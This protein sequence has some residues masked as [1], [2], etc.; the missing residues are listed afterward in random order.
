M[1]KIQ[2]SSGE[3]DLDPAAIRI[4]GPDALEFL[5]AQLTLDLR[6][7]IPDRLQATAWCNANG[8]VAVVLLIALTDA[9]Y[10]LVVPS[11]MAAE[12]QRRIRLYR[13]GRRIEVETDLDIN[14]CPPDA[15]DALLLAHSP[16]RALRVGP[17]PAARED[18]AAPDS[19]LADDIRHGLPW[20]VAPTSD[21]F[22]P[23]MLGL[24]A[25]GGL[26]YRKGCY[27]GQEVIARVHFRGR[28]TRK[29]LRF[30]SSEPVSPEP[31]LEFGNDPQRATVLYS[32]TRPSGETLGL[33]VVPV[34]LD[35]EHLP[36]LEA[37]A[38]EWLDK[39]PA[40]LYQEQ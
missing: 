38:F 31:G 1:S 12:T 35:P 14:A 37:A 29:T 10:V 15:A 24:D 7:L 21:L 30:R 9:G 5:Q 22:L 25:L 8:R 20:I 27:P 23:Q 34:D 26:S 18:D 16:Q 36:K 33:A 39:D 17:E 40:E 3:S 11:S 19:R 2:S 13:I 32:L 4:H 28:V 6:T